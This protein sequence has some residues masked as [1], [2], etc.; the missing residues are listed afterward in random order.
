MLH[1]KVA[2]SKNL[3]SRLENKKNAKTAE[4]INP[5]SSEMK[6]TS[7]IYGEFM[8][9]VHRLQ[10]EGLHRLKSFISQCDSVEKFSLSRG[11]IVDAVTEGYKKQSLFEGRTLKDQMLARELSVEEKTR[12]ITEAFENIVRRFDR[13]LK[14]VMESLNNERIRDLKTL[15]DRGVNRSKLIEAEQ[16]RDLFD[17]DQLRKE[18]EK[19]MFTLVGLNVNSALLSLA[20]TPREG[21][22][23]SYTPR[24]YDD[25]GF[26]D[27][28]EESLDSLTSF[29]PK[30]LEWIMQVFRTH[31]LYGRTVPCLYSLLYATHSKVVVL[32]FDCSE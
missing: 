5:L 26:E 10:K 21:P 17:L 28:E 32:I 9:K 25:D 23:K 12:C 4:R 22:Q 14:N 8:A 11:M 15:K 2:A 24:D 7:I 16:R 1:Q 27:I 6:T 19:V 29:S 30:L 31:E 3:K 18:Q 20:S 13:D